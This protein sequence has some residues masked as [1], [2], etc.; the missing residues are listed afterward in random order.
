MARSAIAWNTR[1]WWRKKEKRNQPNCFQL[2]WAEQEFVTTHFVLAK[3]GAGGMRDFSPCLLNRSNHFSL[4]QRH[5]IAFHL[6]PCCTL[7]QFLF[8]FFCQLSISLSCKNAGILKIVQQKNIWEKRVG[9]LRFPTSPYDNA[10]MYVLQLS[11]LYP[12]LFCTP[13]SLSPHS[14]WR[15]LC[16]GLWYNLRGNEGPGLMLF[17]FH[18]QFICLLAHEL[19]VALTSVYYFHHPPP[20]RILHNVIA[21]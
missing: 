1:A 13:R 9:W 7:F 5:G 6:F 19:R 4:A 2:V 21:F 16:R 18:L 20:P 3:M 17:L 14:F 11:P 8:F 15:V 10:G 12:E